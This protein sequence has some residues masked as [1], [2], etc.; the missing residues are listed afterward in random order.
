MNEKIRNY[1]GVAAIVALLAGAGASWRY[2]GAYAKSIEP[3]SFRSFS[4][5]GEGKATTIPDIAEFSF[6]IITEGGK[7]LGKLQS[8]NT[9]K[10]NGTIAFLKS[11]G[12][13]EKD[14]RTSGYSVE[15][16]YQYFEC[17]PRILPPGGV[18]SLEPCPP[19]EITGY[20]VRQSVSVKVRDFSVAGDLLSGVVKEGANSVSGLSFR[21]DDPEKSR[22]EA[23]EKAIGKARTKAE[24]IAKAG[25]FKVGRLLNLDEGGSPIPIFDQY[26]MGGGAFEKSAPSAAPII[27]PG[28]QEISVTINLRYEI[29]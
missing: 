11:N 23:R 4:V 29:R 15:P 12:V 27:E 3:S 1:L 9:A 18:S 28:S 19:P 6:S 17:G 22:A 20:T 5:Y 2:V 16:R 26:G 24:A 8:E 10:A 7:D 14:I 13:E 25:G 21:V